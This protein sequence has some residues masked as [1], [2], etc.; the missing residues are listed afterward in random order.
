M[1]AIKTETPKRVDRSEVFVTHAL[2]ARG[3]K[4]RNCRDEKRDLLKLAGCLADHSTEILPHFVDLAMKMTRAVS[5]GLSVYDPDTAPNVFRW[6]HLRGTLARFEGATTPRDDSPCGVTLDR[7]GPLLVAHPERMYDW[8]AAE[9][10]VLP[11]V[12]LVPLKVGPKEPWGR[13][14]WLQT[15]KTI[16]T[17]AIRKHW[18]SS[19]SSL[20]Q[21]YS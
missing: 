18:L 15:R 14:G 9:K 4:R 12:L 7:N 6:K 11:E 16:L 3:R 20:A 2:A 13:C 8:I 1:G 21:L 17:A 5:A 19:L 10:L